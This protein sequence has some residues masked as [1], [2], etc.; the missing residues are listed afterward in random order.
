VKIFLPIK[1]DKTISV[2]ETNLDNSAGLG[3]RK[4]DTV[5]AFRIA[6]PDKEHNLTDSHAKEAHVHTHPCT[7][8]HTRVRETSNST[9]TI[10]LS[11]PLFFRAREKRRAKLR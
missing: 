3:E 6:D 10:V 2:I 8:I 11:I 7:H 5:I 9:K 1:K 4:T